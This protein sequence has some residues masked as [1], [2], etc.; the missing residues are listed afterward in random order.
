MARVRRAAGTATFW[1]VVRRWAGQGRSPEQDLADLAAGIDLTVVA[2]TLDGRPRRHLVLVGA[3]DA[4][5]ASL[6]S[7]VGRGPHRVYRTDRSAPAPIEP[8]F[9][10]A[11]GIDG[12]GREW[13]LAVPAIDAPV[14]RQALALMWPRRE[15]RRAERRRAERD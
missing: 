13:S 6:E 4:A 14:F 3:S 2:W 11:Q 8:G 15:R 5:R 1:D 7:L 9:V 10:V 12:E